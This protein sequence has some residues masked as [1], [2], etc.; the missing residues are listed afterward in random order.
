MEIRDFQFNMFAVN[1][2]ILWDPASGDG[3]I[4][5]PGMISS[6]DNQA[7]SSFIS[8]NRISLK[9]LLNTHLHIDHTLG[10]DNIE[11]HYGLKAFANSNDEFL[12]ERRAEQARMFGLSLPRLTPVEIGRNLTDGKKIL[13][14]K[15]E[16]IVLQVPGHSPGSV[17]FYVPSSQFVIT[18]DA[19]FE[20]S[21][22]RTDLPGGNQ[23]EL[24]SSVKSKLLSLPPNT[25]VY[26]GH[27]PATTIGYEK[28]HNPFL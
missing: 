18:G 14:G 3:A 27:G 4:V 15:E 17:A 19:L 7:V 22:G 8:D 11:S 20:G 26:P 9:Y 6:H 12:G 2:Y 24:I 23:R 10:N 5:D 25:V 28:M 1:T 21:I 16:I 13:L